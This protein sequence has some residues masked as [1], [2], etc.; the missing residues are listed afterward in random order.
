MILVTGGT[1]LVGAHLLYHLSLE[2]E[3]LKATYRKNSDLQAVKN[4][5]AYY[6][7]NFTPLFEKINWVEADICQVPSLHKAFENVTEVYHVAALVSFN[8][9]DYHAMRKINIEG[10]ANVVN[11]CIS[12]GVK[13][14]CHV[15]SIAT[16]EKLDHQK[17]TD[18]EGVWNSHH[19][20]HD[21]AITKHGAEM[22]VW[23]ASQ[24]G[25]AVLIVNPGVILGAGFWHN[26]SGALFAKVYHGLKFYTEG[27]T[28]FVSVKDVVKAMIQLQQSDIK[29]ERFVLVSENE[30]FKKVFS[31]MAQNFGK[32]PPAIKVRKWMT[33]IAWR[34]EKIKS[35]FTQ[36]PPLLTQ[37][38]AKS[39]HNKTYYSSNKIK[40]MLN[41]EF[42]P[43]ATTLKEVCAFYKKEKD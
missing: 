25:V 32:K 8:P 30:S 13:K 29:N 35:I 36:K 2:N 9:K 10:T 26:G 4:V 41:F 23:R 34:L 19:H 39:V 3:S 11:F 1:G 42:E 16:I 31:E 6:T 27:V 43:L 7:H 15:S 18:E 21:Y 33:A 17:K 40:K 22:E 20:N 14:L 12:E 24:E 5:F 37:H 28:G 38:T